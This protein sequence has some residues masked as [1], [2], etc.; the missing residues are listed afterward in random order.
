MPLV[1]ASVSLLVVVAAMLVELR[2]SRRNEARL[3]QRGAIEPEDDVYATMRWSYPA[4]FVV[5]AVEGAL[6]GPSPGASTIAGAIVFVLAKAL[7]YWAVAALGERWT[8]RVLVL[9]DASLVTH[10][11]YAFL[12]HPNYT[13]VIG[14]LV[15]MA[16]LVGAPITG[17]LGTLLFSLV[18][19]KR[20]MTENRALQAPSLLVSGR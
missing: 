17:T 8:F 1:I 20:I 6:F 5:M 13:G 14:E 7:K 16:L 18:L 19:R 12:R 9:R 11:P 10:G 15:G 2:I 3:R 4:A